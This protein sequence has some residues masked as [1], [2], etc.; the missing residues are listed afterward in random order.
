MN[1]NGQFL[2]YDALLAFL[3]LFIVLVGVAFVLNQEDDTSLDSNVALDRLSLLSSI[4]LH[5]MNLLL[6]LSE[7]DLAAYDVVCDVLSDDSFVLK[8]LTLNKVL[9][10]KKRGD[11]VDAFC[12]RKV[13]G[14]HEYELTLYV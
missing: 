5:D 14:G 2:L 8:D 12:A 13:V 6:A 7:N 9:V 11:Y 1:S 10:N 4:S 3:I